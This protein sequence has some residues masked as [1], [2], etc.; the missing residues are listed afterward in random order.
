M[1]TTDILND[2][3]ST[4]AWQEEL[5]VRLHQNPEL[6]M[7]ETETAAEITR[8][9]ESFGYDV[10]KIGGG[11]VGVLAN[12]EGSTALFRAD[13]DALPVQ[14]NTG[15]P[16]AST[17]TGTDSDGNVV[18]LMH[19]CGHD[20]HI[21]AGLGAAERSQERSS[22]TSEPAE[23]RRSHRSPRPKTSASFPPPSAS[24]TTTGAS[25][26]SPRGS[27]S[28]P[29]TTPLSARRSLASHMITVYG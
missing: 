10:Q 25:A 20:L 28:S 19:A 7:M 14:E 9:L 27:K 6:S 1:T 26:A 17:K 13:I 21:T 3:E 23:W 8:R 16:Y 29:T 4:N 2:L 22:T 12:G 5:Y 15:L 18:P 11:V 24:R